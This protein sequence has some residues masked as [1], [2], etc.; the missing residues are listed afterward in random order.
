MTNLCNII[1]SVHKL[2]GIKF[3]SRLPSYSKIRLSI[4]NIVRAK[5]DMSDL[6]WI[7]PFYHIRGRIKSK[8]NYDQSQERKTV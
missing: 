4:V 3:I 6:Q 8:V 7:Q 1:Q 2:N 5:L